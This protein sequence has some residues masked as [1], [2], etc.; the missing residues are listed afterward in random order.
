VYGCFLAYMFYWA[1]QK[2]KSYGRSNI[3]NTNFRLMN[4]QFG[5]AFIMV[6]SL[7]CYQVDDVITYFILTASD[8]TYEEKTI[9]W[10]NFFT[11]TECYVCVATAFSMNTLLFTFWVYSEQT[12]ESTPDPQKD[13]P[14][15]VAKPHSS[16]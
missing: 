16:Y 13:K 9:A 7:I 14:L 5:V 3:E 12:Y 1:L 2:I 15:T 6:A 11:V 10:V 4:W 8:R